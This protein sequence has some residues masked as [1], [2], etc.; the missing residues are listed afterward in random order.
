MFKTL[1]TAFVFAS[2]SGAAMAQDIFVPPVTTASPGYLFPNDQYQRERESGS[3]SGSTQDAPVKTELDAA[4][5]ARVR[6]ALEALVPEYNR[7]FQRDGEESANAWI[8]QKAFE[9]GQQEAD[10]MKQR[11]GLD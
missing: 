2:L 8:G 3:T 10:I 9:L 5:Q 11:M 4:A 7:R 6:V 1:V